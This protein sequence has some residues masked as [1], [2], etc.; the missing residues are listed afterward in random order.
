MHIRRAYIYRVTVCPWLNVPGYRQFTVPPFHRHVT[1]KLCHQGIIS[2]C[3][4]PHRPTVPHATN[5][6]Q[7]CRRTTWCATV[8]PPCHLATRCASVTPPCLFATWYATVTPQWH[9]ATWCATETPPCHLVRHYDTT[10]PQCHLVR[11]R[12][13]TVPPCHLVRHRYTTVPP[14]HLV[15]HRDTT[16]PLCRRAAAVP[17]WLIGIPPYAH[18]YCILHHAPDSCQSYLRS[19]WHFLR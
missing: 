3:R 5:M 18:S 6:L 2:Y 12:D 19:F 10:V 14:C 13:T 1:R 8:P 11:Y 4:Q 16:V 17:T 15:R 7:P 9:S